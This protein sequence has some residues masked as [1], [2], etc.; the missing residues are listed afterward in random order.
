MPLQ[1][2]S[3]C[4]CVSLSSSLLSVFFFFFEK[5][6]FQLIRVLLNNFIP[7]KKELIDR[8]ICS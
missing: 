3:V 1:S 8:S 5:D 4:V 6:C 2:L 7:R